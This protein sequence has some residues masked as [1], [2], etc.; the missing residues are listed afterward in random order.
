MMTTMMLSS[1]Q[2]AI[3]ALAEC[4]HTLRV[5]FEKTMRSMLGLVGC[6]FS[7]EII[8]NERKGISEKRSQILLR[9]STVL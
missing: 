8:E 6:L 9:N 2:A 4:P 7:S 3:A 1:F 5:D